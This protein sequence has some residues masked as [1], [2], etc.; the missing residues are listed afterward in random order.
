[1]ILCGD[2]VKLAWDTQAHTI[3]WESPLRRGHHLMVPLL[4]LG[5]HCPILPHRQLDSSCFHPLALP[6]GPLNNMVCSI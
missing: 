3:L 4:P 5:P 6:L 2:S 1:V